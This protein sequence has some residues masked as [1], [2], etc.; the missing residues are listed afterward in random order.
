MSHNFSRTLTLT[1][2]VRIRLAIFSAC[3]SPPPVVDLRN[4]HRELLLEEIPVNRSSQLL[5]EAISHKLSLNLM[6]PQRTHGEV[7]KILGDNSIKAEEVFKKSSTASSVGYF[8]L[9]SFATILG[10]AWGIISM[11]IAGVMNN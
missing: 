5:L 2:Q 10:L 9:E 8:F 11:I 4:V 6:K 1:Y 3:F 7:E